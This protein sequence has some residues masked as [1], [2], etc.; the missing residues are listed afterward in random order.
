MGPRIATPMALVCSH[1]G[2][3]VLAAAGVVFAAEDD[4]CAGAC[5]EGGCGVAILGKYVESGLG[6]SEGLQDRIE[7][8]RQVCGLEAV[9]IMTNF[10]KAPYLIGAHGPTTVNVLEHLTSSPSTLP[11]NNVSQDDINSL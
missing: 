11:F 7:T 8:R 10:R 2:V 9:G 5:G 4:G 6:C 3:S 1:G